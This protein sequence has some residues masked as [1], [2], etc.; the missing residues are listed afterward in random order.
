APIVTRAQDAAWQGAADELIRRAQT[1][2]LDIS[3]TS[4]ALDTEVEMLNRTGRWPDTVCLRLLVPNASSGKNPV[5]GFSGV[6]IIDYEK[7]WARALP[8]MMIGLLIVLFG[9]FFAI[10]FEIAQLLIPSTIVSWAAA[11][12]IYV[13]APAYY[14]AVFVRPSINRKAKVA[15]RTILR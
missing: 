11:V 12:A 10:P 5:D 9:V 3:D 7:S 6:R 2:L 14:Y 8:R 4:S 1:I 15:L 13:I